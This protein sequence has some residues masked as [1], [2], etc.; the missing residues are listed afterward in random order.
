MSVLC[1]FDHAFL[2]GHAGLRSAAMRVASVAD[3][4]ML[5]VTPSE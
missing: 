2:M 3:Y 5:V 1:D 4:D